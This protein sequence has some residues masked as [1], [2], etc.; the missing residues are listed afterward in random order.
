M[1]SVRGGL[2]THSPPPLPPQSHIVNTFSSPKIL[3]VTTFDIAARVTGRLVTYTSFVHLPL[4]YSYLNCI[5]QVLTRQ[6]RLE[7]E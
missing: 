1:I 6:W 7:L 3:L 5:I 2:I 4:L